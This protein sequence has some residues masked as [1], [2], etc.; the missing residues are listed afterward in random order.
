MKRLVVIAAAGACLAAMSLPVRADVMSEGITYELQALSSLNSTTANFNLHITGINAV[1]DTRGG[2]EAVRVFCVWRPAAEQSHKW[3][4][5]CWVQFSPWRTKFG[6][7][8]WQRC[9]LLL[10]KR[11]FLYSSR[12][13]GASSWAGPRLSFLADTEFGQLP[14]M[15]RAASKN[16]LG[17]HGGG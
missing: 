14:G 1:G 11:C 8:R 3:G 4:G 2:R 7:M 15:E 10:Q 5:S 12:R 6:R 13:A 16:R 17:G 9:F